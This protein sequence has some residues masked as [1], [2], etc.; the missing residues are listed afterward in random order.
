MNRLAMALAAGL[1]TLLSGCWLLSQPAAGDLPCIPCRPNAPV[2]VHVDGGTIF[3][4][5]GPTQEELGLCDPLCKDEDNPDWQDYRCLEPDWQASECVAGTTLNTPKVGDVHIFEP[6]PISYEASPPSSGNHRPMWARWGE[7]RYLPPQRWLHNLEHGGIAFLY[8][9]CAAPSLV[10]ALRDWASQQPADLSGHFRWVLTP[11]PGLGTA[12]A[13]V[14]WEWSYQA[15]C[16]R[17]DEIT[18]FVAEHYRMAPEDIAV[19]GDYDLDWL[20]RPESAALPSPDAGPALDTGPAPDA[21][22]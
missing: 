14:S 6:T 18:A 8:H 9:P 5:T 20:S 11:Y 7:Y 12:M 21:G 19:D 22:P 13:V 4:D 15:D 1:T 16:F 10:T 2:H 17:P 3:M